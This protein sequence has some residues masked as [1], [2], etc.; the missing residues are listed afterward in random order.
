[1][2]VFTSATTTAVVTAPTNGPPAK[3]SL[4]I[5]FSVSMGGD[6]A[7]VSIVN[8]VVRV[9]FFA[10]LNNDAPSQDVDF[11]NPNRY[12]IGRWHFRRLGSTLSN[13]LISFEKQ[14]EEYTVSVGNWRG[15]IVQTP[16]PYRPS[17]FEN[18]MRFANLGDI[19]GNLAAAITGVPPA[20]TL[21]GSIQL[22]KVNLAPVA[23]VYQAPDY[24]PVIPGQG[25][26]LPVKLLSLADSPAPDT[27]EILA[28]PGWSISAACQI[29]ITL[30]D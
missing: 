15:S 23:A 3:A 28:W 17:P 25:N 12:K 14:T 1:M 8:P 19:S 22:G 9:R 6:Y 20:Q 29:G 10:T 13:G 16:V 24:F 30:Y 11:G 21:G 7:S 26:L 2:T 4:A 18:S 27:V 5:P